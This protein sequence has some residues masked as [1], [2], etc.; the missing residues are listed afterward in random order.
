MATALAAQLAQ[1]DA[2]SAN[3]LDLKAQRRA[4][5]QSL[6][7]DKPAA[8]SQD[9]DTIYQLCVEGFSDLCRIDPRFLE[10]SGSI[11]SSQSRLEDRTQMTAAQNEELDRVLESFLSLVG[12]RLLLEPARRSI[13]WLIRRFR[14]VTD[15][16]TTAVAAKPC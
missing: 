14:S 15:T 2:R 1:I 3:P 7:F 11:F 10:F 9:F 16:F 6:I 12:G 8:A 5:S 4:H 13:E